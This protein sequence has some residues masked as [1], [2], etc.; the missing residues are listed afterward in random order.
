MASKSELLYKRALSSFKNF[1]L[2]N[3]NISDNDIIF[4]NAHIDMELALSNA[5]K[6]TFIVVQ[7]TIAIFILDRLLTGILIIMHILIYLM[8]F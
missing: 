4:K 5:V 8:I 3:N 7:L 2:E 6:F 1:I